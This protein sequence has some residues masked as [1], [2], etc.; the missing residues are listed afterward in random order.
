MPGAT[1]PTSGRIAAAVLSNCNNCSSTS[2][3]ATGPPMAAGARAAA[4]CCRSATTRSPAGCEPGPPGVLEHRRPPMHMEGT[5]GL[6]RPS[7]RVR[8][9]ISGAARMGCRLP[10]PPVFR[11][12]ACEHRATGDVARPSTARVHQPLRTTIVPPSPSSTRMTVAGPGLA[13]SPIRPPL[14]S[15]CRRWACAI[16]S[17]HG[18]PQHIKSSPRRRRHP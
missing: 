10:A 11:K 7:G 14:P 12:S 17:N 8:F 4:S 2:C 5:N 1:S 6:S 3:T 18:R 15:S 9:H 16:A 13:A